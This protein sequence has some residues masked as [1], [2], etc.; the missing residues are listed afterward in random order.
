[1]HAKAGDWLVVESSTV[2]RKARRGYIVD[3]ASLD[4]TP[5]YRVRRTDDDRTV[6]VFP[7]RTPAS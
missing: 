5:P 7:A 2:D 1:M 3:V 6:L 4:G